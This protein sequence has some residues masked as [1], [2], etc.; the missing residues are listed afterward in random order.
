V[1]HGSNRSLAGKISELTKN[2]EIVVFHQKL[3]GEHL[4]GNEDRSHIQRYLKEAQNQEEPG[5]GLCVDVTQGVTD[6]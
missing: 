4:R 3:K 5:R 6:R 2:A 1:L